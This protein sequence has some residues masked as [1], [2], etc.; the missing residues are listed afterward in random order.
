MEFVARSEGRIASTAWIGVNRAVLD[1][2][3]VM[4]CPVV[5]NSND[6]K[7]IPIAEAATLI[8]YQA[9]YHFLDWR[10]PEG[11]QRRRSA[12]LCEILVPDY[13]PIDYLEIPSHG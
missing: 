1:L 7:L 3:G 8:D 9:L 11:Q 2:P 4:Y 12:E 10:T 5:S 6:A 13:I